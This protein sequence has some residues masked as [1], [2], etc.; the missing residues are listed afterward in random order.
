MLWKSGGQLA[1]P[2]GKL[3]QKPGRTS[4]GQNC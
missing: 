2:S 4:E 1:D 3:C